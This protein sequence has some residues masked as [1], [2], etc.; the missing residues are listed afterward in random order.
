MK[1]GL[2]GKI[3]E[4]IKKAIG[5]VS[6]DAIPDARQVD[7]LT[8]KYGQYAKFSVDSQLIFTPRQIAER[9][10]MNRDQEDQTLSILKPEQQKIYRANLVVKRGFEACDTS[11]KV[12]G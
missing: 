4:E 2:E 6:S 3:V 7:G 10:K 9:D 8:K 11:S 5:I 1:E 12:N